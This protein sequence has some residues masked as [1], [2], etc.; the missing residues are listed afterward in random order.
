MMNLANQLSVLRI[1]M[2]PFFIASVL[3]YEPGRPYLRFVALAIFCLAVVSDF[4]DG[5]L[6]RGKKEVT[7]AGS[8]LDPL[9]DKLLIVGAV[10]C[11][12]LTNNFTADIIRLPI[13]VAVTVI[14]RE[15]LVIAGV[16]ML[17]LLKG[18]VQIIP[19]K[20]GKICVVLEMAVVISA[21]LKFPP[22]PYNALLWA[23]VVLF[24]A[25]SLLNYIQR[26]LIL[27]NENR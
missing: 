25:I 15:V 20:W 26:T 7:R 14:S 3:Y 10:I 22:P 18:N 19:S 6:A 24:A 11:L 13:F 8:Y 2:V 17:F 21:L 5:R 1:L 16:I 23:A 12:S 27:L 9:A 4:F